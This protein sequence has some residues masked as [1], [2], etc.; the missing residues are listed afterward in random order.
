MKKRWSFCCN[1]I[2]IHLF[3]FLLEFGS[4]SLYVRARTNDRLAN[5]RYYADQNGDL[6]PLIAGNL[7]EIARNH[8]FVLGL[9][10]N[11]FPHPLYDRRKQMVLVRIDNN[12]NVLMTRELYHRF[13]NIYQYPHPPPNFNDEAESSARAMERLRLRHH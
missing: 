8:D 13:S 2:L 4:S 10:I 9:L 11:G 6:I 12:Q 1:E 7:D 3:F 5:V